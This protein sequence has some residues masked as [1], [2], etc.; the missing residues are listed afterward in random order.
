MRSLPLLTG[1]V[2]VALL[3]GLGGVLLSEE[4]WLIGSVLVGAGVFRLVFLIVQLVRWMRPDA[5]A[6]TDADADGVP[7][8][9]DVP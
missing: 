5:D 7:T 8:G 1:V 3:G 4:Q 9:R 2:T 6:D